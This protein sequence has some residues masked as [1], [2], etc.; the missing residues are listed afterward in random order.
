M[1]G[2]QTHIIH[3][4]VLELQLPGESREVY[5]LQQAAM[6]RLKD[7]IIPQVEQMLNSKFSP[8]SWVKLPQLEIDLGEVSKSAFPHIFAKLC[9][10]NMERELQPI[11]KGQVST[12]IHRKDEAIQIQ[13]NISHIPHHIPTTQIHY[14]QFFTFLQK[15]RLP[16]WIRSWEEWEEHV[17]D[18]LT[19]MPPEKLREEIQQQAA[20]NSREFQRL[21][22]QFS[23]TFLRKLVDYLSPISPK[24]KRKTGPVN[25]KKLS[26]ALGYE[27]SKMFLAPHKKRFN[28]PLRGKK[29][30]VSDFK[31]KALQK[32]QLVETKGKDYPSAIKDFSVS[33]VE[34]WKEI[35]LSNAGLA[36]ILSCL[37]PLF[38]QLGYLSE[39]GQFES[40]N[41]QFRA[42]HLL[43]F[44]AHGG[45]KEAE[46]FLVLN[47]LVCGIPLEETL[48]RN[49]CLTNKEKREGENFLTAMLEHWKVLKN[50]S[51]EGLRHNFLMREGKLVNKDSYWLLKVQAESF[52][53]F[54]LA[55]LPWSISIVKFKW[56][57]K[58][59]QVEWV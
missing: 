28:P 17:W 35:Y 23:P 29:E 58:R 36:L 49:L 46:H 51:V 19:N 30:K 34:E 2:P 50:T 18:S 9:V 53:K 41:S 10:A 3:K 37:N 4:L 48:P 8:Q 59:I 57:P 32:G 22:E 21:T 5:H 12:R 16:F 26:V 7:S 42:V 44:L 1:N 54:L 13:E 24:V 56:M 33:D 55:K 52:D 14:E 45:E 6:N 15:G 25:Q 31:V 38:S 20:P 39:D 47:K 27:S 11:L 43:Q 40:L